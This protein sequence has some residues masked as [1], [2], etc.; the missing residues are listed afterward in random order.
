MINGAIADNFSLTAKL[1]D[2]H[3]DN[4][5]KAKSYAN[6]A[7]TI[8]K[9]PVQLAEMDKAAIAGIKG[10]GDS[11]AK[12]II[13]QLETGQLGVLNDLISQTPP[14]ILQML[15]IKG[16]GP[17]K[18][19][20]I[21]RELEIESLGELLY[22]CNE[23]RL[24]LYK[25]FGEKTQA[26]IKQ[27]IEFYL[28][29]IGSY[30][31]AQ[32]ESYV[33]TMQSQLEHAF[34]N[35]QFVLT[36]DMSRQL[37]T[38]DTVEWVTDV[39]KDAIVNLLLP[40]GY[41]ETIRENG[42]TIYTGPENIKLIFHSVLKEAIINKCFETSC[43]AEFLTAWKENFAWGERLYE[44]EAQ[45][46][47]SSGL[48]IIPP[49]LR[50]K[51]TIIEIAK[52]KGFD[53]LIGTA[54]ITGIIHSHSTWSDGVHTIEQMANAAIAK[55]LQYLVISDHSKS[56]FYAKGLDETRLIAQQQQIDELNKKLF[57]FRIFKSIESDI[58]NDGRLD[59]DE[60]TLS[61]FDLVIASIHSNL[62]MPEEKAMQRLLT[63]IENPYTSILGHM[64]GRLLLSRN[65]YPINHRKIIDACA[66]NEVVIELNAHPSRL[67]IDW[68][69][70]DYVLEKNV[71]ISINPDAHSTDGFED[72]K[73][74][75]IAARKAAVKKENNLS[76]FALPAFEDFLV[77]QHAKRQ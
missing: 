57:P 55:G 58:L 39:H 44:S 38:T 36:G 49:Y 70:I 50:E 52:Q 29:N 20:T 76:S 31:Y 51:A 60:E 59:Y 3:G 42:N 77:Q 26:N 9:L 54:D 72:V 23:N 18:I 13:E 28:S 61:S 35:H 15:E 33:S 19:A 75:V 22:A 7:F 24:T 5:F 48:H 45:L 34:P 17:K 40:S 27:G 73:Y 56:A 62:K 25:G 46:F 47:E 21:W 2:I 4:P 6:A 64:T 30:L 68:R 67:D 32:V 12:K 63:A 74:G 71:L 41:K 53:D 8:D 10:I 1:M 11:V 69:W 37:E 43:S 16:I 14:G 65:G 66:A